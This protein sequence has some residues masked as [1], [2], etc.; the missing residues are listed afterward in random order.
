MQIHEYLE[1]DSDAE[2]ISCS[3]CGHELCDA[4]R[5]YKEY[6]AM[7]TSPV[8][9]AGPVFHPP[10]NILGTDPGYEFR[11][12]FCPDCGVLFDHRFA[13]EGDRIVHDIEID[14][15]ALQS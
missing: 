11:E 4:D 6:S 1:L 15:E 8:T 13:L 2:T 14:L 12:W 9:E 3:E 5:N 10:G 7:R